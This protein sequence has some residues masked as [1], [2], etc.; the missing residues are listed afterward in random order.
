MKKLLWGLFFLLCLCTACSKKPED[1]FA[2]QLKLGQKYLAELNYEDAV[3]AFTKAI[4]LEPQNKEA[5]LGRGQA[6]AE[7]AQKI[8]DQEP[9][10]YIEYCEKAAEDYEMVREIEPD[11]RDSAKKLIHIYMEIGEDEKAAKIEDEIKAGAGDVE[12]EAAEMNESYDNADELEAGTEILKKMP[13]LFE[14]EN[15]DSIFEVME[16]EEFQ[17]IADEVEDRDDPI[18]MVQ[19]SVGIGLYPV[20]TDYLGDCM[21]Y[22]GE[23]R[24]GVR[25]GA[26]F[27]LGYFEGN[28]YL[29]RGKWENDFPNGEQSVREWFDGLS[30]DVTLLEKSGKAYRGLWDGNVN[31]NYERSNGDIDKFIVSFSNGQWVVLETR[32][33]NGTAQYVLAE[34]GESVKD[35]K[36]SNDARLT[37]ENARDICGIEGFLK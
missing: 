21:L 23:Y 35:G 37:T 32:V 29:A 5:Y 31:W 30:Q 1:E 9:E 4:E 3:V 36:K 28:R 22:Y 18:L 8:K 27:W 2:E 6:Y 24:N 34:N 12:S 19:D 33:E 11:D 16:S 13:Q 26:G 15:F 10:M 7:M 25:H 20:T 14:E 17:D